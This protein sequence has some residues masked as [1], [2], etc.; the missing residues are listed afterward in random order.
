M[1]DTYG[2]KRDSLRVQRR[3]LV[4]GQQTCKRCYYMGKT[5]ER[6]GRQRCSI[7]FFALFPIFCE[8]LARWDRWYALLWCPWASMVL[9]N[10]LHRCAKYDISY[11]REVYSLAQ[12]RR[13][14]C[15]GLHQKFNRPWVYPN[16]C[17]VTFCRPLVRGRRINLCHTPAASRKTQWGTYRRTH[18]LFISS[19]VILYPWKMLEEEE[20]PFCTPHLLSLLA[21]CLPAGPWS[22]LV[23]QVGN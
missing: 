2:T 1:L 7:L 19:Y 20:E 23:W 12:F 16:S 11:S 3:P 17:E 5:S 13:D 10:F 14:T 22:V 9:S 6:T 8:P 18:S 15:M 21:R 4:V